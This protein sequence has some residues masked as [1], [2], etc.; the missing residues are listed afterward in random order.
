MGTYGTVHIHGS[1]V[2][3]CVCAWRQSAKW[4]KRFFAFV[5][6]AEVIKWRGGGLESWQP[7]GSFSRG[8]LQTYHFSN[9][10]GWKKNECLTVIIIGCGISF[11]GV[12]FWKEKR[13]VSRWLFDF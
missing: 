4:K 7:K 2:C 11:R 13:V 6:C 5:P 1:C 3:D 10:A 8:K 9:L 12:Y